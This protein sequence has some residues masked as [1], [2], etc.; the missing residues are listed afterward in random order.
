MSPIRL[1]LSDHRIYFRVSQTAFV[2]QMK[3]EEEEAAI[4]DV[5]VSLLVL[6]D[7]KFSMSGKIQDIKSVLDT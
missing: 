3:D 5:K 4:K 7:R 2:V 6:Y 1:P